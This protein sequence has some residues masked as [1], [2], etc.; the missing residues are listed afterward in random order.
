[1]TLL[2]SNIY[3][4]AGTSEMVRS[5]LLRHNAYLR[6]GKHACSH[7]LSLLSNI[8]FQDAHATLSNIIA[9][10]Y[11]NQGHWLLIGLSEYVTPYETGNSSYT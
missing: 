10:C 6:T 8:M 9:M 5:P 4:K 1:M 11:A 2:A 3:C 7:L